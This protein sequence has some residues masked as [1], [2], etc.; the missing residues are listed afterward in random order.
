M[1]SMAS[2]SHRLVT[3]ES[4]W[5]DVR[6]A[7]RMLGRNPGFSVLAMLSLSLSIAAN[8]LIFSIVNALVLAPLAVEAPESLRFLQSRDHGITQ[9]YP[10]YRDLRAH[11]KTLSGLIGYR[12][13]PMNVDS[14]DRADRLWGYLAT[15]NYFDVLG[16]QPALG[17]F[18]HEE[19]AERPGGTAFAVL[20]H[21]CW[22]GRFLGDPGVVG[23]T[24]RINGQP[25][26]IVGVAPP[27]F[28]GTELF[29]R[30]EIWVPMMMQAQIEIG[31]PWLNQRSTFN[32][33][34]LG[35]LKPGITAAQAEA[36]LNGLAAD[37][38][39]TYAGPNKG[40]TV[41]LALPGLAG[42]ALREPV[43]AFTLGVFVLAGLVLLAGCA[44]LAGL[45]MARGTDR[46]REMAL[47]LSI[48]A[49]RSRLVRACSPSPS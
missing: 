45:L 40:M 13:A 28:H 14:G 5:H 41:R 31:N 43:K 8:T 35:R 17:Q 29:Y 36:D 22:Q 24:V 20:S 47:R 26:T 11:N 6:Y 16:I 37:L 10:N 46:R 3:L 34:V 23:R 42:D 15:D 27:G 39:R 38:A 25:F 12:M 21:A 48:G 1:A 4:V 19:R 49:G 7:A 44:N 18:F 2:E 32:T 30:P 33:W 9:S